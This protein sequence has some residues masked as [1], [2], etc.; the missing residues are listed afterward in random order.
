MYVTSK[1]TSCCFR[2]LLSNDPYSASVP[3][4]VFAR[5]KWRFAKAVIKVAL[6]GLMVKAGHVG[7]EGTVWNT[8]RSIPNQP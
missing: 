7:Y 6:R 2:A 5:D 8:I 3:V 1:T 4:V